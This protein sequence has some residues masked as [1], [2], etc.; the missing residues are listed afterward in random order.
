MCVA[1]QQDSV[2]KDVKVTASIAFYGNRTYSI[3]YRILYF[4]VAFANP[5]LP[6]KLYLRDR[7][8]SRGLL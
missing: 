2:A 6:L 5:F 8:R 3:D 4:C 7:S 1:C